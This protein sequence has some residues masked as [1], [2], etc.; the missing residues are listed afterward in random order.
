M[1][2]LLINYS[3]LFILSHK[4]KQIAYNSFYFTTCGLYFNLVGFNYHLVICNYTS[5]LPTVNKFIQMI[6]Q[7]HSSLAFSKT[8]TFANIH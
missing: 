7:K 6:N 2:V 8:S 4:K 1:L 3:Y 5:L